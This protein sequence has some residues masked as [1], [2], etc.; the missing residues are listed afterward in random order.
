MATKDKININITE[1]EETVLKADNS[2]E[3]I[4]CSGTLEVVNP[5]ASHKIWNVEL[6]VAETE[7][8]QNIENHYKRNVIPP[9][10]T[11]LFDYTIP[12]MKQP[13]LEVVEKFDLSKEYKDLNQN[14]TLNAKNLGSIFITLTNTIDVPITNI[15]VIKI[16]P[17]YF[18]ETKIARFT[19]GNA[20]FENDTNKVTWTLESLAPHETAEL[21][22]EGRALI[23]DSQK[24]DGKDLQVTYSA[25]NILKSKIVANIR[26]ITETMVGI[27]SE[28]D[29]TKPGWWKCEL[30]FDN[31]S[32]FELTI[33]KAEV[34]HKTEVEDKI[35]D[36][37]LNVVLPPKQTW[38]HEFSLESVNVPKFSHKVDFT[39]NFSVDTLLNGKIVKQPSEFDV[40]E[41]TVGKEINPP[42]VKANARSELR[43]TDSIINVGTA[44]I[45]D[46]VVNDFIPVDFDVPD[47]TQ[48]NAHL[49]DPNG[50]ITIKFDQTN[51]K[52]EI[53]PDNHDVG[54]PH[55]I[56][57]HFFNLSELTKKFV[58]GS[59]LVI[60]YPLIAQNPQPNEQYKLKI[61]TFAK[62]SPEGYPFEFTDEKPEVQIQYAKRKLKTAKAIQPGGSSGEFMVKIKIK[63][64][65]EVELKNVAVEETVPA[66]F[67]VSN[68]SPENITPKYTEG[69]G[70]HSSQITWNIPI[71]QPGDQIVFT[72]QAEGE[73]N[74]E[75]T[76]PVVRVAKADYMSR[77]TELKQKPVEE[78]ESTPT[79]ES[80]EPTPE[81]TVIHENK[82]D[83][84]EKRLICPH[85]NSKNVGTKEDRENPISYI[86]GSPIYGKKHYCK[87][88]GYEWK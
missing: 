26:A 74:F 37:D 75:R 85:C 25:L 49:L 88:C 79:E 51:L 56:K 32:D 20:V 64:A 59:K 80:T 87:N 2:V 10:N 77:V 28:E 55:T 42:S 66:G 11:W 24:K 48:L 81:S 86:S 29:D 63:N 65:G 12:Q 18:K 14:F 60:T 7:L 39:V 68:F 41:T 40:L 35:L 72:Y 33:T 21:E 3:S 50:E 4:V 36:M 62:T 16:L 6:D 83:E 84:G 30:E 23:T 43:I 45:D 8:L 13:V 47:I 44:I 22:I 67:K 17:D 19:S 27:S 57:M 82:T 31:D 70:N 71:M 54:M 46:L 34:V 76:E 5:S 38:S 58:P 53:T 69:E 9:S 15:T 1:M 73:G 52:T 78:S 61:Q